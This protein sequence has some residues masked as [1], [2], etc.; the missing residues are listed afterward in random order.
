M[1]KRVQELM[2]EAGFHMR[3]RME[4]IEDGID[5]SCSSYG[6]DH[7][8]QKFAELIVR[9]CADV[10]QQFGNGGSGYTLSSEIREHFGVEE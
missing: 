6:Y 9:E 4:G 3:T 8:V 1:N 2:I 5:W 7:A 10:C